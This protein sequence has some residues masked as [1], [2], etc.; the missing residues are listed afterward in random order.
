MCGIVGVLSR[1]RPVPSLEAAC[2][3]LAHRGP[4]DAGEWRSDDGRVAFGHRRLSILDPSP[5]GHQPFVKDG[6]SLSYNGEVYNFRELRRELEQRGHSFRSHSDTEVVLEAY[7]AFGADFVRRLRGMFA[8]G[9]WDDA[10]QTLLLARDRLGIKPLFVY[11][12]AEQVAFASELKALEQCPGLRLAPDESA[13]YD[14]LTYLYVPAPKTI[15]GNVRKV[16]PAEV[17]RVTRDTRGLHVQRS[18]YWSVDF[19]SAKGPRGQEAVEAVRAALADATRAHLV[20]D[21]PV[22]CLLSG[23]IDSSTIA[24]LAAAEMREPLR[25]FALGFDVAEHSETQFAATVAH[26]IGAQHTEQDVDVAHARTTFQ[27]LNEL[28]DEPFGD[29]S[30]IP[31]L[32]VCRL[33]RRSVK[34]A[35]SGDGGDEVFGGYGS[36]ARHLRRARWFCW[37]PALVQRHAPSRLARTILRRLR[38]GPTLI[39]GLRDPLERHVVIQGGLTRGDKQDV[40]PREVLRRFAGYDDLWAFRAHDRPE[41]DPLTRFQIIDLATYLPDA[42]LTKVDRASMACSLELRPP[43]L[44]HELVELVAS[45]PAATRNPGGALKSLLKEAMRPRLPEHIV[46]RKKK[47][48]GVPLQTWIT[49]LGPGTRRHGSELGSLALETLRSWAAQHGGPGWARELCA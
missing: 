20:S 4:D 22:G 30:A 35:L 24:T 13:A 41:L 27:R 44:D 40:L 26:G 31:T 18:R 47:G 37:V 9:L 49:Q 38:G 46:E 5:D 8:L 48:F 1:E 25:T 19:A 36:Y 15:Y 39:D 33:A 17:V 2:R 11:Q 16:L 45:I 12:D 21:V 32:E 42:I 29:L 14:F 10:R 23:G 28:Y 3:A 43:L 34:V 7:R 6:L